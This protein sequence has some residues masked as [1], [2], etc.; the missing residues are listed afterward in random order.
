MGSARCGYL[1][2]RDGWRKGLDV[3]LKL[4]GFAGVIREPMSIR[5]NTGVF[6]SMRRRIDQD[7]RFCIALRGHRPYACVI[8][9]DAAKDQ[10]FSIQR[11]RIGTV[12]CHWLLL[13]GFCQALGGAIA[14]SSLRE[15]SDFPIL[16]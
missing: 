5:R 1:I 16:V 11:P 2:L 12:A 13:F 9:A 10:R 3:D 14:V 4:A 15:Q 8:T 6:V 7:F